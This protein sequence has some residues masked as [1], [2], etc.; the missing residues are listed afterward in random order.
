MQN[1]NEHYRINFMLLMIIILRPLKINFSRTTCISI[2]VCV[3]IC[4]SL[5]TTPILFNPSDSLSVWHLS[6][7]HAVH[8]L[9][10]WNVIVR[11]A[12]IINVNDE[13]PAVKQDFPDHAHVPVTLLPQWFCSR[14]SVCWSCTSSWWV[15]LTNIE[16]SD[17]IRSSYNLFHHEI[18]ALHIS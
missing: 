18:S 16:W 13:S 2:L 3:Y 4:F 8:A 10:S 6:S 17:F 14:W 15:Q 12:R 7:P 11:A 5:Q 1:S 9:Y